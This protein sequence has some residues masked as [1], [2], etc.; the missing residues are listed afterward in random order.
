MAA[1][2]TTNDPGNATRTDAARETVD[3]LANAASETVDRWSANAE[4]AVERVSDAASEYTNRAASA[5]SEYAGRLGETGG[6]LV[7]DAR[8]YIGAHPL[9]T[10]GIAA[11]AGFLIG[12]MMR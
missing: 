9:R 8:D 1:T 2:T 11:A 7:E 12:R 10:L 3:R 6:H 5:A 4:D